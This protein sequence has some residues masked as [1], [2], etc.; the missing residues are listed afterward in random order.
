MDRR[1]FLRASLAAS[2]T[3]V[4]P[5]RV[6]P[7]A[8]AAYPLRAKGHY[9]VDQQDQPF[10]ML[11]D[12]P[13]PLITNVSLADAEEYFATR[14]RQGFNAAWVDLIAGDYTGNG[15]RD[16]ATYD[17]IV[18]FRG[19]IPLFPGIEPSPTVIDLQTHN[20][21]Y[22]ERAD[23]MIRLAAK[24]GFCFLLQAAETGSFTEQAPVLQTNGAAAC[25]AYGVHLG[26]RYKDFPN[27]IWLHGND[28][29]YP[30]KTARLDA[31]TTSIAR[32]IRSADKNHLHTIEFGYLQ[33]STDDP[34]WRPIVGLN[35]D[36]TDVHPTYD[37]IL[38]GYNYTPILPVVLLEPVYERARDAPKKVS[39]AH[40]MRAVA[41]WTLL[42]G[43]TGTTY[44]NDDYD[45]KVDW[46]EHMTDLGAAH[47]AH[48][49]AFFERRS[50][51]ELV[52]DQSHRVVIAGYGHYSIAKDGDTNDYVTTARTA[53]GS[54]AV[55]Y[56]PHGGVITVD[57]TQLRG[58]A[59]A[60][61]YDPTSGDYRP[62][63]PSPYARSRY[64]LVNDGTQIFL[65][66]G[67]NAGGDQDWVL[68]IET[69]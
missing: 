1:E 4:L 48:V 42:S 9:L 30:N 33:L 18:P 39:T 31:L 54:L 41:Y 51:Y 21:S 64:P 69:A 58:P 53:D 17:G 68:V 28:Y 45:F 6:A 26:N 2:L 38:R 65:S 15:H 60:Q 35:A 8:P 12:S 50:W 11:A 27:I 24:F 61:W 13:Q 20:E 49:K 36:Y 7:A 66:P 22:F 56:L 23:A 37:T 44:G 55:A 59:M 40:T 10:L 16:Y 47:M 34:A 67:R 46:R 62:I 29:D 57:M 43:A 63:N 25:F 32:G 19:G 3:S 14:Q 52:P 5:S